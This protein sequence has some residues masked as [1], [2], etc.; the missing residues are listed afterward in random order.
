MTQTIY[1]LAVLYRSELEE[2]LA[3][4]SAKIKQLIT[5]LKGEILKEDVWGKREMAYPIKKQTQACYIFYDLAL[6]PQTLGKIETNLN[7]AEEVLRYQFYK[8]DLKA[9]KA[10]LS[11]PEPLQSPIKDSSKSEESKVKADVA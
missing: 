9:L 10:A 1:E 3:Q 2:T 7:I 5:D 11:R 6:D 8:P 4:E